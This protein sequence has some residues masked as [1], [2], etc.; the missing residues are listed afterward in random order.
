M[1]YPKIKEKKKPTSIRRPPTNQTHPPP[2]LIFEKHEKKR[3]TS[4]PIQLVQ[5]EQS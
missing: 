2:F 4:E 1:M 3:S 5:Q